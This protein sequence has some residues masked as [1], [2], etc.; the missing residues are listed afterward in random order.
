MYRRTCRAGSNGGARSIFHNTISC[1]PTEH[2]RQP[3]SSTCAS[4]SLVWHPHTH[5]HRSMITITPSDAHAITQTPGALRPNQAT[6]PKP[7]SH[8]PVYDFV[9]QHN[10]QHPQ[11]EDNPCA[12][13][14]TPLRPLTCSTR[15]NSASTLRRRRDASTQRP[16]FSTQDGCNSS[17]EFRAVLWLRHIL[18]HPN[19]SLSLLVCP[20]DLGSVCTHRLCSVAV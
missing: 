12:S 10:E 13:H 2:T 11:P 3:V 5:M 14:S 19:N 17:Y 7:T 8:P 6:A 9:H 1:S 16:R 15:P 4:P 20:V 18:A